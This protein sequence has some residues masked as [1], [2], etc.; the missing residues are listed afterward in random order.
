MAAA[1]AIELAALLSGQAGLAEKL[2]EMR[3][4]ASLK[5]VQLQDI[6]PGGGLEVIVDQKSQDDKTFEHFGGVYTGLV[7]TEAAGCEDFAVFANVANRQKILGSYR[8]GRDDQDPGNVM[9]NFSADLESES[10]MFLIGER[11]LGLP[12]GKMKW[13][14]RERIVS[15]EVT[16]S[17]VSAARVAER[18][19]LTLRNMYD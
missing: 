12:V 11:P 5:N 19:A 3:Q 8:Y 14:D 9:W 10:Y 18:A 6:E 15:A 13:F 16:V 1:P 17:K 2:E 7:E 4:V